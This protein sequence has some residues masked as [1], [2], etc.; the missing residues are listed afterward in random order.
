MAGD[1]NSAVQPSNSAFRVTDPD[2]G[3]SSKTILTSSVTTGASS[4]ISVDS[5]LESSSTV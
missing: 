2:S 4:L 1:V 3:T 5:S